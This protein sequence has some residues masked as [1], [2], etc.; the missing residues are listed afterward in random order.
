MLKIQHVATSYKWSN[1]YDYDKEF[2]TK[3]MDNP[4]TNWATFDIELFQECIINPF[5]ISQ[6]MEALM[7]LVTSSNP[8]QGNSQ[9]KRMHNCIQ[10]NENGKCHFGKKCKFPHRCDNCRMYGHG[11][12]NCCKGAKLEANMGQK[13]PVI[14]TNN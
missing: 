4:S 14:Q 8:K 5:N 10:F 12:H 3:V 11:A 7:N 9:K 2:R 13:I 1:V 6:P